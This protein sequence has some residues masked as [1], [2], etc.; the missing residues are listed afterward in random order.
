[1]FSGTPGLEEAMNGFVAAG[2]DAREEGTIVLARSSRCT[3]GFDLHL[4]PLSSRLEDGSWRFAI[5]TAVM[6]V[7][8]TGSVRLSGRDPE[9]LPVI[10]TGYFTDPDGADLAV[11]AEGVRMAR[12]LA[13]QEPLASLH[14]GEIEP[15]L[16]LDDL[17]AYIRSH[18][19]HDY[20]PTSTCRMGPTND[21]MAV[22]DANGR[23][24]GLEGLYVADASIMP[25]VPRANTNLPTAVVG[26]K[27]AAA[28]IAG[29]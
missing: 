15:C 23:V 20:H 22:V 16:P 27:I 29:S 24:H 6:E 26:E 17:P 12:E 9:A 13:A 25:F 4:Y 7:K 21:P 19:L 14:G 1:V 28:L 2:G 18:S 8:S 5:Y 3:D 11:L 10:D